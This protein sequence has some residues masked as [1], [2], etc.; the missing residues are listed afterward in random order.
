MGKREN[1]GNLPKFSR[2]G[3][4]CFESLQE[5]N[6]NIRELNLQ[7]NHAACKIN[8][9]T[10]FSLG[11]LYVFLLPADRILNHQSVNLPI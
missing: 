7:T 6:G 3:I 1:L 11:F 2:E 9:I 5:Y 10:I 4:T 8:H